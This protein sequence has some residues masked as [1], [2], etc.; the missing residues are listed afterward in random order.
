[1]VIDHGNGEFRRLAHMR[2]GSVAL[3]KG[4]RV[5]QGDPVGRVGFSGS[6]YTIHTHYQLQRGPEYDADGL[7]ST[8]RHLTRIGRPGPPARTLRIDSG[9][10]VESR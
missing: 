6:V 5:R 8:F 7:P 10:V 3:R 4:D 2:R 1:V 9:D